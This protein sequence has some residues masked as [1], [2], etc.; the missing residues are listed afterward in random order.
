MGCLAY[1]ACLP[2]KLLE[3]LYRRASLFFVSPTPLGQKE[4]ESPTVET[5]MDINTM[6]SRIS[7]YSPSNRLSIPNILARCARLKP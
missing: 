1:R 3:L 4:K 2:I 7:K 5:L 6:A